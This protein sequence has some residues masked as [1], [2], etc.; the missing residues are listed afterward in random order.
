MNSDSI[1]WHARSLSRMSIAD[2]LIEWLCVT[3]LIYEYLLLTVSKS[4]QESFRSP[5]MR[6]IFVTRAKT[7]P[8]VMRVLFVNVGFCSS[9]ALTRVS[10][11]STREH[12]CGMAIAGP[13]NREHDGRDK[14]KA[15][16]LHRLIDEHDGGGHSD[17]DE[18]RAIRLFVRRLSIGAVTR[19]KS[20]VIEYFSR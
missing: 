9:Q 13:L 15:S 3:T 8:S 7:I 14:K 19:T 11:S 10:C 12:H 18:K 1:S 5:A 20:S 4:T 16:I 17:D 2:G 6:E